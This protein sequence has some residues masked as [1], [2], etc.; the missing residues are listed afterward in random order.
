VRKRLADEQGLPPYVIFHD[1]TLRDIATR[2]P[3]TLDEFAAIPGVGQ[4][5]LEKYGETFL[6]VV[7]ESGMQQ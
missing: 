4:R 3:C 6:E 5:K 7:R 1:A 2:K